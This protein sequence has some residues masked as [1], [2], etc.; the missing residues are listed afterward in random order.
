MRRYTTIGL[1]LGAALLGNVAAA[2]AQVWGRANNLPRAGVCFY[3]DPN[4]QGQY[5]CA[6]VGASASMVPSGTND[7]ISSIRV[8]G[9]AT[10]TVYRDSDFRGQSKVLQ[11][12][13]NSLR[14]LGFNDRISS[15]R[16][17]AAGGYGGYGNRDRDVYRDRNGNNGNWGYPGNNGNGNW[18]GGAIQPRMNYGQAQQMVRRAYENVLRRSPD[19]EGLRSWSEQ[20]V[21]NNWSQSQLEYELRQSPEYRDLRNSRRR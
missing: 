20:V 15:Y 9:N 21:Q 16:V 1:M 11:N 8:L 4:F 5:F 3:E 10:V 19:R 7:K 2:S 18:G 14:D 13:I 6:P 12:D 17:D